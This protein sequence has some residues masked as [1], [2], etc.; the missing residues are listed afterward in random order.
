MMDTFKKILFFAD[1]S[2]GT[3]EALRRA[4]ELSRHNQASLTVMDVVTQFGTDDPRLDVSIKRLQKSLIEERTETLN[5]WII[6]TGL[7]A[8]T[9]VRVIAGDKAYVDIIKT[10]ITDGFDLLVKAADKEH[11][12]AETLFGA[13]DFHLLRQCPC[14]V[15]IIKTDPRKHLSNILAA[16]DMTTDEP[17][18]TDLAKRILQIATNIAKLEDA[19]V[20][21]LAVWH[22]PF[23]NTVKKRLEVDAWEHHVD[24]Y[25]SG[26]KHRFERLLKDFQDIDVDEHLLRGTP[27]ET[28]AKFVEDYDIDLLVMG[29]LSREGIPGFLIGNT[30]ERVLH[31]VDCSV[32]TLKPKGFHPDF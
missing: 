17:G 2:P 32:L 21:A 30:A 14:P 13:G 22:Q 23:D 20:H 6:E 11:A 28:I 19:H 18:T 29:T 24:Q 5:Q 15:W 4:A 3:R 9:D 27:S 8:N 25:K 10:V 16:V 31:Q 1:D 26:V 7:E 12:L